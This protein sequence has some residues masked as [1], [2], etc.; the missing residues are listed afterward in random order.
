MK[1]EW[2]IFKG[3]QHHGP[4][5]IEEV[6]ELY[7]SGEVKDQSLVWREGIAKWEPIAKSES[8]QFLFGEVLKVTAASEVQS[9]V[10]P[11]VK[12]SEVP[13]PLPIFPTLPR[14]AFKPE[15]KGA[16]LPPPIPLDAILDPS[17]ANQSRFIKQRL[18]E[19]GQNRSM[20][21]LVVG[22]LF[23]ICIITWFALNEREAGINLRI[24]GL[25]PVYLEKLEIT[26][27]NN[28]PKFESALALS[29]DGQTLWASTNQ[30]GEM[31]AVIKLNSRPKKVLG[32]GPVGLTVKGIFK[33]HLGKFNQ[34]ILTEGSKFLP[35]EYDFKVEAKQI[36]FIN[37]HFKKLSGINFFK[38]LNKTFLYHGTALIYPGTPREFDKKIDDYQVA[39]TNEMLKPFQDKLERIQ[40]YESLINEISQNYLMVL[41]KAKIGKNVADFESKYIKNISLLLQS[42]VLKAYELSKDPK[43][44]ETLSNTEVIAPYSEQV[45]IGKQIGEMASDMITKTAKYKKLSDKDKNILKLEFENRSRSIKQQIEQNIKKLEA[46]IQKISKA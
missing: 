12:N 44:N 35:G 5:S 4:F 9:I 2:F 8:F 28:S 26:A 43:F 6:V 37:A 30:P 25:M 22:S 16:E 18:K 11:P 13:P 31:T 1:K 32:L 24:K 38:S 27:T 29:L 41:E 33:N 20:I 46:Q 15:A 17:G 19:N 42:L 40:T 36:H 7:A 3:T 39:I 21:Y 45:A 10:A 34:M 23:F 14:T